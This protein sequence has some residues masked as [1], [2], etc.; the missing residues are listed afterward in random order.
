[1]QP[2][3]GTGDVEFFVYGEETAQMPKFHSIYS[4]LL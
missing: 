2:L 4:I 3:G 1:V